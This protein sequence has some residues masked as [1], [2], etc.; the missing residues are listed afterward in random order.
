MRHPSRP[1]S[2]DYIQNICENFIELSGDRLFGDDHA[3]IGGLAT[4]QGMKC[5]IIGQEKGNDTESRVFRNFGY[6]NPEGY[7]KA[8]RLMRLAEK[9]NLPIVTMLDTPGA[10]PGLG[11]E[12]RGIGWAIADNLR[13]IS[14]ML[15]LSLL[16]L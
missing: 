10:N 14:G 16:L 3:I 1:H 12:E 11:A 15:P 2:I 13:E 7:R 8:K 9:F 5:V 6:P 4:I